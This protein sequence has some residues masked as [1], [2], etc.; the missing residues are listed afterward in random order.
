MASWLREAA[1][2]RSPR[3]PVLLFDSLDRVRD[4]AGFRTVLENDAAALV[5]HG[6]GVMLTAPVDIAWRHADELRA[7]TK[8][9][10]TLPY[11]DPR[12]SPEAFGFLLEIL[13]RRIIDGM[14]SDSVAHRLVHTSGGILRDL[15]ELARNAVEEAYMNGHDTVTQ[16]DA[17]ASISR[18][19]RSL[20]LGLSS[21]DMATLRSVHETR[22]LER[23]DEVTLRLLKNRQV[24][25]H[26]AEASYFEVAS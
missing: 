10:D 21:A 25:E 18:F 23:F 5:D 22:T 26:Y 1:S 24:I 6:F 4:A 19:A 15:I 2:V 3:V 8:S 17:A 11:E 14:I 12:E 7:S 16:N 13:R 9:W 20:S